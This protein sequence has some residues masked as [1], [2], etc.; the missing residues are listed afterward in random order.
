GAGSTGGTS[1]N[2]NGGGGTTG[3]QLYSAGWDHG[4][5]GKGT[6]DIPIGLVSEGS[7]IGATLTWQRRMILDQRVVDALAASIQPQNVQVAS[8]I[9]MSNPET[10]KAIRETAPFI[11]SAQRA[12]EQ[13]EAWDG[14]LQRK[15]KTTGIA[16]GDPTA[17]PTVMAGAFVAAD[18]TDPPFPPADSDTP[19]D[20]VDPNNGSPFRGVCYIEIP[21]I[22]R[23]FTGVAI[24]P[25]QILTAAHPFDTDNNGTRD[26]AIADLR[27][28]FNGAEVDDGMG[29]TTFQT[30]VFDTGA[31][32]SIVFPDGYVGIGLTPLGQ[33][34]GFENDLAVIT[35]RENANG[36]TDLDLTDLGVWV[37]P[38][39][40]GM[41]S[42]GTEVIIAGYGESGQG[43][44]GFE[45]TAT[46][47]ILSNTKRVGGNLLDVVN[48]GSYEYDFDGPVAPFI[49]GPYLSSQ[50]LGNRNID[51][52]A[53]AGRTIFGETLHGEGDSGSPAFVWFDSGDGMGGPA[54]GRVQIA[55][56]RVFGINTYRRLGNAQVMGGFGA[57]G[58]GQTLS[59]YTDFI[60]EALNPDPPPPPGPLGPEILFNNSP[61]ILVDIVGFDFQ[62]L[63]LELWRLNFDGS[64]NRLTGNSTSEWEQTEIIRVTGQEQVP[65]GTYFLRIVYEG[66]QWDFGGFR[67][68][69][70]DSL[71]QFNTRGTEFT[72]YFDGDI[73]YGIAWYCDLVNDPTV[74]PTRS[75]KT[76]DDFMG[77]MNQDGYI[78]GGDIGALLA[79]WG[80][81]P[82]TGRG[83]LN[84]DGVVD[85]A[86]LSIQ[87]GNYTGPKK[88]TTVASN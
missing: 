71:D 54:D 4:M 53:G 51:F 85:S 75:I 62:K 47:P 68:A 63:N 37:Y 49:E 78:D 19:A 30:V 86:D 52:D 11:P 1:T 55:E 64:G 9:L 60:Q 72:N 57:I 77:D 40:T 18:A 56:I 33:N 83:D 10:Q 48:P 24:G 3:G 35:L 17:E 32:E 82:E 8:D 74:F 79:L 70:V 81:N 65:T 39:Q 29:G 31:A 61:G 88:T 13:I 76:H 15:K 69:G 28:V 45:S 84:G 14:A 25:R 23:K 5:I 73:E 43:D 59:G 16:T 26:T 46:L 22:G 6:L 67:F 66:T 58:G 7:T 42:A 44:E 20:R 36:A 41:T 27:I 87:L 12:L 80:T 38:T 50:S 21:S 2:T 34:R